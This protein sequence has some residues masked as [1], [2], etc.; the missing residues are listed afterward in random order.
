[1]NKLIIF[2]M[3]GVVFKN[4]S[5]WVKLHKAYGTYTEGKVLA[6][7][8]VKTNYAKLVDEV[9][10]K[11][12]KG[13][14]AKPYYDLIKKL[15]YTKG[16]KQTF[17]ELKQMNYKTAIISSGPKDLALRAKKEL[18]IDYIFTNDL[19]IKNNKISGEFKWPVGDARKQVILRNLAEKLNID[20]KD[21]IV[22]VHGDNDIRMAK[23]A[24]IAIAFNPSSK[25]LIKYCCKTIRKDTLTSILKPIKELEQIK[26]QHL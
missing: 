14:P 17:K 1:M 3:D 18:K 4:I 6:E 12:W 10:G 21:V 7:K 16:A 23:T 5:F 13:K 8:Y 25:E 26:W 2:D 20:L 9:V 11:L 24:G 19:I 22:V 15:K